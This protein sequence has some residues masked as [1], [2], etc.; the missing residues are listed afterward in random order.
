[1]HRIV[2]TQAFVGTH[3][4]YGAQTNSVISARHIVAHDETDSKTQNWVAVSSEQDD[5]SNSAIEGD[6][7][8]AAILVVG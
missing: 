3:T 6:L 2:L 8:L 7:Y 4:W 5:V 1:M